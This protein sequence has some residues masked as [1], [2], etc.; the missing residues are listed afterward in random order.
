MDEITYIL[1]ISY[2][3][4]N[5]Y[6]WQKQPDVPTVQAELENVLTK[7]WNK[8]I[9]TVGASRTDRGVHA[10]D[11]CVSFVAEKKFTEDELTRKLNL[12]LPQDIAVLSIKLSEEKFDARFDSIGKLYTYKIYFDKDPFKLRYSLWLARPMDMDDVE[13]LG[14]VS[15]L[16]EGEHNFSAFSIKK[17]LPENP[18]CNIKYAFWEFE[19]D[20]NSITFYINGN[21]FLHKMVRSLVGA[22]L[23]VA[24][25][26]FSAEIFA[27]MLDTGE[28]IVEFKTAPP[29]GLTLEKVYYKEDFTM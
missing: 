12:M 26:K 6:G 24:R 21:R 8:P 13:I 16:L 15:Q 29:Q 28:R 20:R 11:Q 23:D 19:L 5:Y 4:T 25:G 14:E 18:I 3:G 17:D 27:K 1:K 7:L 2:D 9:R 10:Q 22:M